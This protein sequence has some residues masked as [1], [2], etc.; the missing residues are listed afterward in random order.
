MTFEGCNE[1]DS[2][3]ER[4]YPCAFIDRT[5][6][7]IF[8]AFREF[9]TTYTIGMEV[10]QVGH[11]VSSADSRT[12]CFPWSISQICT[13][14]LALSLLKPNATVTSFVSCAKLRHA[15]IL[16]LA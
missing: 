1:F 13:L 9:R 11:L 14:L 10:V 8:A 16:L 4:P 7:Q 6:D 5:V 3:I 12:L 15:I 2:G